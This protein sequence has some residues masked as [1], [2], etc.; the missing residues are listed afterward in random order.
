MNATL[1]V[2]ENGHLTVVGRVDDHPIPRCEL[3][4]A[5]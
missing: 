3:R 5:L 4:Q 1:N 2:N